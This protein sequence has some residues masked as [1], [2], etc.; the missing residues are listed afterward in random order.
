[1]EQQKQPVTDKYSFTWSRPGKAP[2]TF[3]LTKQVVAILG[4]V[5]VCL[6]GGVAKVGH[7]VYQ[8]HCEQQ[9]LS[10]YRSQYGQQTEKLQQLVA[11]NEK[12]QKQLAT[13]AT[14]ENQVRR[15]LEKDGEQSSR[16]GIDRASRE[17]DLKGQGGAGSTQLSTFDLLSRQYKVLEERIA[18]KRENLSNMLVQLNQ[19][20]ATPNLW[21]TEGGEISSPYGGRPDPFGAG[22]DFHP[23]IDIAASYGA[24]VYASASGYVAKAGWNGGYGRYV[25]LEHAEGLTTAYGHMSALA[26]EAGSQVQR[27]AIIGYVGSS[28]YSTG[29]HVHFEV[30]KNGEPTDPL[31]FLYR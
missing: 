23:G 6:L 13:L 27:G 17:A 25:R 29:P 12:M 14:L 31:Q 21:P 9:E 30:R 19:Q 26:V 11:D 5:T 22:A 3:Y 24:P 18:Y 16:S 20:Q 7:D 1:M 4:L 2:Q 15:K 8:A 10:V 28:G